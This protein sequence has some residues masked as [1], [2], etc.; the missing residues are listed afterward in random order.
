MNTGTTHYIK[1]YS[2]ALGNKYSIKYQINN[3]DF[4]LKIRYILYCQPLL[5][6][7]FFKANAIFGITVFAKIWDA[8]VMI[9][10]VEFD[11]LRLIFSGF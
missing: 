3:G 5:Q 6:Y 4:D 9:F 7:C 10:L 2:R 11:S 8:Q 1:G